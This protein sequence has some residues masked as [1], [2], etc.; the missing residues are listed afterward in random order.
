MFTMKSEIMKISSLFM[1]SS[2]ITLL[3]FHPSAIATP[4]KSLV[5]AYT[6]DARPVSFENNYGML[7]GYC[8]SLRSYLEKKG[9]NIE[10]VP[11][12][13][14]ERFKMLE[15]IRPDVSR[16]L[17]PAIECGPSTIT[18][19]RKNQ[20]LRL[21]I[22]DKGWFSNPFFATST[23]LIINRE[24]V[25]KLYSNPD[26]LTIGVQGATTNNQVIGKVFPTA[27]IETVVD[28]E[29]AVKRLT[30]S[31]ANRIDAYTGDEVI[32]IDLM[33]EDQLKNRFLI[34]PKLHG[35]TREEYGIVVY[36][37]KHL[38]GLVNNWISEDGQEAKKQLDNKGLI[39]SW[40]EL[41]TQSDHFHLLIKLFFLAFLLLLLTNP[42]FMRI[43]Y[44][45]CRHILKRFL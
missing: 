39:D 15:T 29:D 32:L 5:F 34:E 41:I 18:N 38:L 4:T 11:I 12:K 35:F 16:S 22:G 27:T 26:E 24:K 42:I 13:Y 1:A 7:S 23:K 36:N 30:A 17:L 37:D 9:Y 31:D 3:A 6:K 21:G 14:P 25:G 33:K 43:L 19:D 40:G 8:G 28:R 20:L 2:S 44:A 10:D 45:S